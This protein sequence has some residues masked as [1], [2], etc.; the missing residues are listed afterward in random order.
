MASPTCRFVR[1]VQ[2][3]GE[4]FLRP[5]P[6][7]PP[8]TLL[9]L[10]A[11]LLQIQQFWRYGA[12]RGAL[13]IQPRGCAHYRPRG[14]TH[15]RP[16]EAVW[17]ALAWALIGKLLAKVQPFPPQASGRWI[18]GLAGFH[19]LQHEPAR[20][21]LLCAYTRAADDTVRSAPNV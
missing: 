2:D 6:R 16:F 11:P 7:L 4:D 21:L 17:E 1:F 12:A 9:L 18:P 13:T 10:G 3:H 19:F 20:P 5:R 15:D 8:C 14:P